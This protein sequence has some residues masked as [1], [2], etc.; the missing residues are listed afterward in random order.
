MPSS[1]AQLRAS[2]EAHDHYMPKLPNPIQN[3]SSPLQRRYQLALTTFTKLLTIDRH[4]SRENILRLACTADEFMSCTMDPDQTRFFHEVNNNTAI[5]YRNKPTPQTTWNHKVFL[6]VQADLLPTGWPNKLSA[7][8]RATLQMESPVIYRTL[9][10]VL[11]CI[12]DIIGERGDGR[13]VSVGLDLLRSI[14]AGV[15]EGSDRELIQI[16]GIGPASLEKLSQA[17]VKNIRRLSAMPFYH[18]ERVLRRNPPFGQNMLRRVSGFPLLK[19]DIEVLDGNDRAG[20]NGGEKGAGGLGWEIKITLGYG[21]EEV[22]TW[23]QKIP[24]VTF[25]IEGD[26]GRLVWFW[27]GSVKRLK[28][29][30]LMHVKLEAGKGEGLTAVFACEEIVGTKIETKFK[31]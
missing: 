18:I 31:I 6:L 13:G 16:E 20:S 5:P 10:Q 11:R 24:W 26:D 19:M 7:K 2:K 23:R 25:V 14:N 3:E 4:P 28:G 15:W 22:P 9:G 27:R 12:I 30:K 29:G 21:N 17:G 8:T 1:P